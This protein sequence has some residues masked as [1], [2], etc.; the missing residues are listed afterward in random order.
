MSKS[1]VTAGHRCRNHDVQQVVARG[2][3]EGGDVGFG[4][5]GHVALHIGYQYSMDDSF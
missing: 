5:V 3:F 2:F 4:E 1:P